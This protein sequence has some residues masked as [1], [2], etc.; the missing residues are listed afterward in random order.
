MQLANTATPRGPS[1]QPYN[2]LTNPDNIGGA[3][4]VGAS[5]VPGMV[6][7]AMAGEGVTRGMSDFE[8]GTREWMPQHVGPFTRDERGAKT[9]PLNGEAFH[10]LYS[11]TFL[12][13]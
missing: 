8:E 3:L 12:Q 9:M 1:Q 5:M 11:K 2:P 7:P 10:R 13:R 6:V 4:R